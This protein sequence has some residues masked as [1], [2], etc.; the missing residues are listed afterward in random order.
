MNEEITKEL[1]TPSELLEMFPACEY[2][3]REIGYLLMLGLVDGV[4]IRYGCL[5]SVSS[6][7]NLLKFKSVYGRS[8]Y[9][10]G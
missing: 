2:N 9:R 4:K 6:F 10:L 7:E 5:I 8:K 3:A 1:K